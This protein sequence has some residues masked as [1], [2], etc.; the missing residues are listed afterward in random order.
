[1]PAAAHLERRKSSRIRLCDTVRYRYGKTADVS[2]AFS[3]Q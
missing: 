2:V 1:M 3:R